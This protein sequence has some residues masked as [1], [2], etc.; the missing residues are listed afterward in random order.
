MEYTSGVKE[1]FYEKFCP[2]CAHRDV[3]E[4]EDPCAECLD[5]PANQDSHK[6]VKYEEK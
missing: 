6:P 3:K 4:S 2:T 1:V 5:E